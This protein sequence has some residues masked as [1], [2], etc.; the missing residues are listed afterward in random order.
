MNTP[1]A[2]LWFG[3]LASLVLIG[4]V[5]FVSAGTLQYGLAWITLGV[6]AVASLPLMEFTARDPILLENRTRTGPA[7]EQRP[8]Q[9]IIVAASGL[10]ALSTFVV[11]GLDHR[12][13]W[14]DVP[15]WLWLAGDFLIL[16]SLWMVYRVFRENSFGSATVEI[17]KDQ[18]VVSTGPYA[19][20]RHP[21][22]ASAAVFFAG[23]A[24]ALGS[25][26][27]LVPA[28]LTVLGLVW[29]LFDEEEF[30]AASLPGYADYR[31]RVRW[32]LIPGIF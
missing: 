30:L 2:K 13:G 12:F 9:R 15:L 23:T 8:L 5:L 3:F 29:R 1:K 24:L 11:P 19:I 17:G 7:A 27:G 31:A 28:A 26:W 16:L 20:V 32:R 4:L 21:M 22:Y 10:F 18:Q 6:I 25:Y 14:S